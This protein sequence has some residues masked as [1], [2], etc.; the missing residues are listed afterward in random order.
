MNKKSKVSDTTFGR[1]F[2]QIKN[3]PLLNAEEERILATR[4]QAGDNDARK[5]MIESNLRLVI[6][7]ARKYSSSDVSFMDLVQEG[8]IGLM[9]AVERYDIQKQVR[10]STYACWWIRQ[11]IGHFLVTKRRVIRLPAAKEDLCFRIQK[12][13]GSLSQKLMHEPSMIELAAEVGASVETV[14]NVMNMSSNITFKKDEE[15]VNMLEY[16]E[17]WRY[18]PEQ[19]Y[20]QASIKNELRQVLASL[21]EREQ[22]ILQYRYFSDNEKVMSFQQVGV[23]MGISAETARQIELRVFEKIH[24]SIAKQAVA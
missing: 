19:N 2:D 1:Y 4:I 14:K 20:M 10:F 22:Q 9:H 17:D 21:K 5:K 23:L 6:T 12:I 18:N 11:S 24:R 13:Y 16:Y 3:Y 8:N 15:S 7:V